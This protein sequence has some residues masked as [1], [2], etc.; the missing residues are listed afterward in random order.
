MTCT[1]SLGPDNNLELRTP[2]G[3]SILIPVS[4]HATDMLWQVLWNATQERR[5]LGKFEYHTEYPSQAIIESWN[6]FY[7]DEAQKRYDEGQEERKARK[8]EKRL[9]RLAAAEAK[10]GVKLADIDFDL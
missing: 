2:S 6:K 4:P 9:E 10:L 3:R 7:S 5:Q 8:E 1:I